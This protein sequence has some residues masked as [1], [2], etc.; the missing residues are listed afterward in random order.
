MWGYDDVLYCQ[1]ETKNQAVSSYY[2]VGDLSLKK[3]VKYNEFLLHFVLFKKV[4]KQYFTVV[5]EVH[6]YVSTI[7]E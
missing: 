1:D 7:Y 4:Q 6:T 3:C 2:G 5:G